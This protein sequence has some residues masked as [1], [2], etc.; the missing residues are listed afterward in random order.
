MTGRHDFIL[1]THSYE[2]TTAL[3]PLQ[4]DSPRDLIPRPGL[5]SL[6]REGETSAEAPF[7]SSPGLSHREAYS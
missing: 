1:D 2:S 5:A 7:P 3:H 4:G 6:R